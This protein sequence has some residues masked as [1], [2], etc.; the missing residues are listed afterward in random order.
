MAVDVTACSVGAAMLP[1]H[2]WQALG[3]HHLGRMTDETLGKAFTIL[4]FG[5]VL[6]CMEDAVGYLV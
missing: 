1:P 2:L 4:G 3:L 5:D 6:R